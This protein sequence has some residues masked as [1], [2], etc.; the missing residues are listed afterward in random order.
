LVSLL[1]QGR[2]LFIGVI[3]NSMQEAAVE[4]ARAE[5]LKARAQ[6]A[7]PTLEHALADLARDAEALAKRAKN[8]GH[9]HAGS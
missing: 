8:L 7:P 6:S 1:R 9:Q 3:M 5:E 2:D 4:T